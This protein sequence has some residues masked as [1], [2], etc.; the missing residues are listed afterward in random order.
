M[1]PNRIRISKSASDQL[2]LLKQRSGLTPNILCRIALMLSIKRGVRLQHR[3]SDLGG[4]E[5]N[6]PTLFGEYTMLYECLL[7]QAYG[8][9]GAKDAELLLAGHIDDGVMVLKAARNISDLASLR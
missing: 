7:R 5:F 8:K 1:F 9:L 3:T 4:L 2:K 6:L